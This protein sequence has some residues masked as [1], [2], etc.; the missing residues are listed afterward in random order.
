MDQDSKNDEG[1]KGSDSGMGDGTD[2]KGSEGKAA[3]VGV[4]SV[5][6]FLERYKEFCNCLNEVLKDVLQGCE[7]STMSDPDILLQRLTEISPL[8]SR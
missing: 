5:T 2:D 8:V 6:E 4:A 3:D 7:A 1:S